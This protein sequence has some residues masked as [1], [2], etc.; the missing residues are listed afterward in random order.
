MN[1]LTRQQ[2][3]SARTR[4]AL[5]ISAHG[6]FIEKGY[7]SVFSAVLDHIEPLA[8]KWEELQ[9][10]VRS[11]MNYLEQH[12]RE[13]IPVQEVMPVAGWYEFEDI[14]RRYIS[15]R[16]DNIISQLKAEQTIKEYDSYLLCS[17]IHGFMMHITLNI[18]SLAEFP[19]F[20]DD[21]TEIYNNFLQTLKKTP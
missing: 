9:L 21:F 5:L 7:Q 12:Y 6:L 19:G 8:D 4:Q 2:E 17:L 16:V 14:N 10:V 20:K 13:L 15:S 3:N 18:K 11:F 1:T